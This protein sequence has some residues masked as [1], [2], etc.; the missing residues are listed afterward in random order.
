MSG[1]ALAGEHIYDRRH[2]IVNQFLLAQCP[3]NR[4][5]ELTSRIR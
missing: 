3:M 4:I 5:R 2:S 1:T